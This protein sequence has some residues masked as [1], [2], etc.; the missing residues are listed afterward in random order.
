[1]NVLVSICA[2]GGSKGIPGKNI[3][4]I[5]GKPLIAYS[6]RTALQLAK[7]LGADVALSTDD[8][9]IITT[10]A[11]HGLNTSYR[12]PAEM[13]TD[14]AGKLDVIKA[15]LLH[16]EKENGKRYDYHIDL[17]VTSPLRNAHDVL[18]GLQALQQ[19]AEAINLFSVSKARRNPYFN[20]VEV[21]KDGFCELV[22][23]GN[24]LTRQSAPQVY[25][26]NASFY[27]F[28]RAFFDGVFSTINDRSIVY[29]VP[30]MCF[31]MD[32]PVDFQ[33][34]EYLMANN[35]LDFEL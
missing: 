10:A 31:D 8:E 1:M 11:A 28:K 22:K 15:I 25:E 33:F 32:E 3:K 24:F 7:E 18:N 12:R 26:L 5:D 27:I 30:H 19:N 29:D 2:R 14:Q 34:M 21:K 16:S 9:Q 13:A 4:P 6:I 20:M 35:Q 17:D 23:K